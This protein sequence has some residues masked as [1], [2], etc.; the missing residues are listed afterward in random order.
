MQKQKEI[1]VK[2]SKSLTSK[3]R[4]A[5]MKDKKSDDMIVLFFLQN[6]F[7]LPFFKKAK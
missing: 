3:L 5:A 6:R 7:K 2:V 4:N 1:K